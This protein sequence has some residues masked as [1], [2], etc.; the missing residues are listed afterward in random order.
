[1]SIKALPPMEHTFHIDIKGSNTGQKWDGNFT[2]KRPNLRAQSEIAKTAARLN[3]DLKNIDESMAFL[4]NVLAS[5]RHSIVES[6][7]WWK[8]SDYGFE[9]YDTNVVLD[10]YKACQEFED[11][12]FAKVWGDEDKKED[13][14]K[15]DKKKEDQKEEVK[16]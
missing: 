4:H 16:E 12:W 11:E 7:E 15:E 5:L 1:M 10:I 8:Q 13:K 14:K 9:L 6:P 3:E 2:Y